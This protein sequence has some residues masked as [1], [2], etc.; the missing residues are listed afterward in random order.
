M[1]NF[2]EGIFFLAMGIIMIWAGVSLEAQAFFLFTVVFFAFGAFFFYRSFAGRWDR[3]IRGP[4]MSKQSG[5]E[6][7]QDGRGHLLVRNGGEVSNGNRTDRWTGFF[8]ALAWNLYLSE[9]QR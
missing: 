7:P 2:F 3:R 8:A 6:L 9:G 5:R 4:R 1:L